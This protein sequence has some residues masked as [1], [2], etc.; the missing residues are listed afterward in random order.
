MI[1][2][3][4]VPVYSDDDFISEALKTTKTSYTHMMKKWSGF[5]NQSWTNWT[6]QHLNKLKERVKQ[7]GW[8]KTQLY[9]HGLYVG[10]GDVGDEIFETNYVPTK[11]KDRPIRMHQ[12]FEIDTYTPYGALNGD[13]TRY[14]LR[15]NKAYQRKDVQEVAKRIGVNVIPCDVLVE[16]KFEFY[17]ESVDGH[18]K[19]DKI[20][21]DTQVE[22][23]VKKAHGDLGDLKC[24]CDRPLKVCPL[25]NDGEPVNEA[26]MEDPLYTMVPL[27]PLIR[28]IGHVDPKKPGFEDFVPL[29]GMHDGHSGRSVLTYNDV[30]AFPVVRNEL[31]RGLH[32][33]GPPNVDM[34]NKL[35]EFIETFKKPQL[36]ER[37]GKIAKRALNHVQA[38]G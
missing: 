11:V 26:L 1:D 10:H 7:P 23:N 12:T 30:K 38:A 32:R 18:R 21:G 13:Y 28:L 36:R 29:Y 27:C 31:S 4:L 2:A 5:G 24:V 34:W 20:T 3:T 25:Y 17:F 15:T 6:Q 16:L 19:T 33:D 8:A 35:I 14:W 37:V 22:A 9:F